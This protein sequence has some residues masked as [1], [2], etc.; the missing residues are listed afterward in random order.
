MQNSYCFVIND[1]FDHEFDDSTYLEL[2]ISI[3]AFD[4]LNITSVYLLG[5][6]FVAK[7]GPKIMFRHKRSFET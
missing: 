2:E 6:S 7:Q 4:S 3:R 5:C 1:H